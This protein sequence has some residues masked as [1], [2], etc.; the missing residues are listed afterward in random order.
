[1][2]EPEKPLYPSLGRLIREA[3]ACIGWSYNR[4]VDRRPRL[5]ALSG[6]AR[7]AVQEVLRAAAARQRAAGFDEAADSID[8][9]KGA[10]WR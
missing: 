7:D 4:E 10:P 9:D 3:S 8:P 5:D 2:T 6:L 1:M